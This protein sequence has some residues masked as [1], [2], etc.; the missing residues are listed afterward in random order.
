MSTLTDE[1]TEFPV[2]VALSG[3]RR[4]GMRIGPRTTW[5]QFRQRVRLLQSHVYSV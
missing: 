4:Q 1:K 5:K 3:G 2:S